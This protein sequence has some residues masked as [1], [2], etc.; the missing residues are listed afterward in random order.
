[1]VLKGPALSRAL[2]GDPGLRASTDLDLLVPAERLHEAV[3]VARSEGYLPPPDPVGRSGLPDM[4]F[5]LSHAANLPQVELHWTLHWDDAAFSREVL[6]S[7][8]PDGEL[9]RPDGAALLASLLLFYARDGFVGLRYPSDMAAW[10]DLHGDSA[11]P[12]CL[13]GMASRHPHV[14][15]SMTTAARVA[16]PIV[17]LPLGRLVSRPLPPT[18]RSAAAAR[19]WNPWGE[20]VIDQISANVLVVDG[21][22][23]TRA[24]L[25]LFFRRHVFLSREGLLHRYRGAARGASAG[26]TMRVL[27]PI[28]MLGRFAL[29]LWQS[30]PR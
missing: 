27:H 2:Y 17:G 22:L 3:A 30:R 18:I 26:R 5:S 6:E 14:A 28:K 24:N 4:H 29:A 23:A 21:L 16:E 15:M 10:W 1:V 12:G 8:V 13:D 11:G 9:S 19:L 25:P 7:A 20:G